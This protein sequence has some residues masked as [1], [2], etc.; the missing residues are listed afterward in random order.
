MNKRMSIQSKTKQR[1]DHDP[2]ESP[3]PPLYRYSALSL[4]L[5]YNGSLQG[6]NY[7]TDVN[8]NKVSS[9]HNSEKNNQQRMHLPDGSMRVRR[10]LSMASRARSVRHLRMTDRCT[11]GMLIARRAPRPD[12]NLSQSERRLKL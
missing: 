11:R 1:H 5:F 12:K 4:S 7:K 2:T 3:S 10:R 6:S 9:S 8:L